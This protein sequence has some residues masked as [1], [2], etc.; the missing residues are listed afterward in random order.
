[1]VL[2]G[3]V[4]YFVNPPS[5]VGWSSWL[6]YCKLASK[7]ER[8]RKLG[9]NGKAWPGPSKHHKHHKHH[10]AGRHATAFAKQWAGATNLQPRAPHMPTLLESN[11]AEPII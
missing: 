9:A 10:K 2:S 11:R 1:M 8:Q 6:S 3:A 5:P 7:Q 4:C